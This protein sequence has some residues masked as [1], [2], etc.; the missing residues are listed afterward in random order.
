MEVPFTSV[1]G[2]VSHVEVTPK[3][4]ALASEE[5][6]FSSSSRQR[7]LW[8]QVTCDDVQ[9]Q[10]PVDT[11]NSLVLPV[12][13]MTESKFDDVNNSK[14][15][16]EFKGIARVRFFFFNIDIMLFFLRDNVA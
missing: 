1:R 7:S 8:L 14:F 9:N 5:T 16:V 13:M 15:H 2:P 6:S 3:P 4:P 12:V 11:E 10:L